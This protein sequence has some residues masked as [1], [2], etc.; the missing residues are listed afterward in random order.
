MLNGLP[1]LIVEEE[2]LI[3]LD[4]AMAIEDLEGCP[5]GPVAT[6]AEA[7]VLLD[8]EAVAAAILDAN[9]LGRDLTPLIMTLVAKS[10]PFVIHTDTGIADELA[11]HHPD[12]PI[13]LKPARSTAILAALLQRVSPDREIFNMNNGL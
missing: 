1:I 2:H 12:L 4:L 10:V 11:A 9:P 13:I 3:A 7:L 8:S 6:A 5:V